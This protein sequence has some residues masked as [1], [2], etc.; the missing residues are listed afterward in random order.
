MGALYA[1]QPL[2]IVPVL[3]GSGLSYLLSRRMIR[4]GLSIEASMGLQTGAQGE[5][6][7]DRMGRVL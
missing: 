6:R 3:L 4:Q 7:L 5:L 2:L 1:G